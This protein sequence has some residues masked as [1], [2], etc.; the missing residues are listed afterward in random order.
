MCYLTILYNNLQQLSIHPTPLILTK[1]EYKQTIKSLNP[2]QKLYQL[3]PSLIMNGLRLLI[4]L[5]TIEDC[6]EGKVLQEQAAYYSHPKAELPC[7]GVV[8]EVF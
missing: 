1:S 5:V 3:P 2:M 4:Q 8:P 7:R 6:Q